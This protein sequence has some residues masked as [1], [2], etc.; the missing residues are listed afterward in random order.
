MWCGRRRRRSGAGGLAGVASVV[1]LGCY[2]NSGPALANSSAPLCSDNPASGAPRATQVWDS[3]DALPAGRLSSHAG[4]R[5]LLALCRA[6]LCLRVPCMSLE[7]TL[8]LCVCATGQRG[9]CQAGLARRECYRREGASAAQWMGRW[10]RGGGV[11]SLGWEE[12]AAAAPAADHS[13][14]YDHA[15]ASAW[16][17]LGLGAAVARQI[18]IPSTDR[19]C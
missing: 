19:R 6:S 8:D 18:S 9:R 3:W 11:L 4:D 7:P 1:L 2:C 13:T 15:A 14:T 5:R 16:D 10:Q 17:Y 12:C